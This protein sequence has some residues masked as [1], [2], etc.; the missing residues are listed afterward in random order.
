MLTDIAFYSAQK[1][2]P[3][4]FDIFFCFSSWCCLITLSLS[5][6]K[7]IGKWFKREQTEETHNFLFNHLIQQNANLHRIRF[8]L[9]I[10]YCILDHSC[11]Y[12]ENTEFRLRPDHLK[13]F[14]NSNGIERAISLL[15]ANSLLLL[16]AI[17]SYSLDSGFQPIWS[18]QQN[19]AHIWSLITKCKI[20]RRSMLKLNVRASERV[21]SYNSVQAD[22]FIYQVSIGLSDQTLQFA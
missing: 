7:R 1:Q 14:P 10:R 20:L 13:A 21:N 2:K 11:N 12:H 5:L 6:T 18:S 22:K 8:G 17:A 9:Q 19:F 16:L 15:N 3:W 4:F